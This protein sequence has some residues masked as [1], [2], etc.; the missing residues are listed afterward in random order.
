MLQRVKPWIS[1]FRLKTLPLAFACII[2][3]GALAYSKGVFSWPVLGLT[4]FTTLCLQ[5]LSNL[6]NDYGDGVKGTDNENRLGP[7]RAVQSGEISIGQMKIG[8]IIAALISLVSGVS[9]I[10]YSFDSIDLKV[11]LFFVLGIASIAAAIKYTVG[12]SAYGY[13]GFG[14]LFVFIFFGLVGVIGSAYLHGNDFELA[15]FLPA[16]AIGQLS[17]GVLNLNNLRD[18]EN[19]AACG[20]ITLVVKMGKAKAIWYHLY[21]L[22]SSVIYLAV[23]VLLFTNGTYNWLFLLA[24]PMLLLNAKTVVTHQQPQ[25]LIPSLK[26][27]A[28]TTFLF[29]LL[30]ALGSV[31]S[32]G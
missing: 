7:K 19:D 20:K 15:F 12:K 3:G 11:L 30:I 27:L 28:L 5:V 4:L 29:S 21:L 10:A 32:Y 25:E 18:I 2:T 26:Q 14:D 9:L 8:V 24:L 13:T 22:F 17:V 1:A 6:A 16:I 31:L 23:F